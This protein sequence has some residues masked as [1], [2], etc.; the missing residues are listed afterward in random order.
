MVYYCVFIFSE[1]FCLL[2]VFSMYSIVSLQILGMKIHESRRFA[3]FP[4][5]TVFAKG[6]IILCT[7]VL[8]CTCSLACP[9]LLSIQSFCFSGSFVL[10]CPGL[11]RRPSLLQAAEGE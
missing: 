10:I 11:V 5:R 3:Q 2:R 1:V 4:S 9:P 6:L 8:P 7:G